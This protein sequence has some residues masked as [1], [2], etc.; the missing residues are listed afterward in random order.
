M[1]IYFLCN[2]AQ[3][4][5][6]QVRIQIFNDFPYITIIDYKTN[7]TYPRKYTVRFGLKNK[8]TSFFHPF[9]FSILKISKYTFL[10]INVLV[11]FSF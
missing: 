9:Q 1:I 6:L 2:H 10:A 3:N 5:I 7:I 8:S 4:T 11:F